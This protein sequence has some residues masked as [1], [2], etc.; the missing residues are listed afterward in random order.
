M[1]ARYEAIRSEAYGQC[2]TNKCRQSLELQAKEDALWYKREK[3]ILKQWL[4]RPFYRQIGFVPSPDF[5]NV[6]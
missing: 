2:E 1:N 3:E 4:K 6:K 5:A